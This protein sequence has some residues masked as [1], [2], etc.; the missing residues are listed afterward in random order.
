MLMAGAIFYGSFGPEEGGGGL[1][2][3][4]LC[5]GALSG[6]LGARPKRRKR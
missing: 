5:G 6:I 4:A 2:C 3:G 1:L